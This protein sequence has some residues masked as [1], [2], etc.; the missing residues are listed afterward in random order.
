MIIYIIFRIPSHR[1]FSFINFPQIHYASCDLPTTA[2]S[3][4]AGGETG[5]LGSMAVT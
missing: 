5:N 4:D 1:N 2:V 3:K